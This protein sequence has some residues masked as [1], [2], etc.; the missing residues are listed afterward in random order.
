MTQGIWCAVA[1]YT[2]WGLLAVYWK[3]LGV[4]PAPQLLGHRIAWSFAILVVFFGVTRRWKTV[5]LAV[6]QPRVLGTYLIAACLVT[7]N[8]LTYVWAVN[9]GFIVETSLGYFINPLVSVTLGVVLLRERLRPWQWLPVGLAA[10]GVLYLTFVYG[11]LPWIALTLAFS[12]G[13]YGLVKKKAPLPPMDGL[14]LETGILFIPAVAYLCLAETQGQGLFLHLSWNL[15]LLLVG[16]GLV[17]IVPLI[18]FAAATQRIP[19]SLVGILQYIA[20]TLQ[21]LVGVLVFHESVKS[22]IAGFVLVWIALFIFMIE[23]MVHAR[24]RVA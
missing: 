22:K 15:N 10:A 11:E 9:A 13:C 24:S 21:F 1:A 23:S 12:F 8:W 18:L 14:V 19:L 20:P 7:V 17:T 16:S 6:R 5:T 3:W 4:V 2:M